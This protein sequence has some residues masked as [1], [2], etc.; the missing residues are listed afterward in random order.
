MS[1]PPTL[2]PFFFRRLLL[3]FFCSHVNLSLY[4][5][6]SLSTSHAARA[7]HALTPINR[8]SINVYSI[9]EAAGMDDGEHPSAGPPAGSPNPTLDVS[10]EIPA[11]LLIAT[12][13]YGTVLAPSHKIGS[14]SQ[15]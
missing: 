5:P 13:Y 12:G 10:D 11:S 9:H 7:P 14:L 2:F 8:P 4:R 3:L 6:R 1:V 15:Q